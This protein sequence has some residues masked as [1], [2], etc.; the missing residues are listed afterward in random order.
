MTASRCVTKTR[1]KG[2]GTDG[3]G[4]TKREKTKDGK[5]VLAGVGRLIKEGQVC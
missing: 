4:E 5:N 2:E 1:D 3:K